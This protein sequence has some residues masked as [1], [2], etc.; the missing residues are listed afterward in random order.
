MI[1]AATMNRL[2]KIRIVQRDQRRAAVVIAEE[3]AAEAHRIADARAEEA[4]DAASALRTSRVFD[5]PADL[6]LCAH[7]AVEKEMAAAAAR[8]AVASAERELELDKHRRVESERDLRGIELAQTRQAQLL[9]AQ[10]EKAEVRLLEVREAHRVGHGPTSR[11]AERASR[12]P[13]SPHAT[14]HRGTRATR[15]R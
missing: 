4:T 8:E 11:A 14:V 9:E 5:S 7:A 13:P 6:E 3:R 1:D 10:Q 12:R 2:A 15:T